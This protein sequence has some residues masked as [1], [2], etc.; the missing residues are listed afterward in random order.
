MAVFCDRLVTLIADDEDAGCC[1]DDVVSDGFEF[2]DFEYSG[3][4]GEEP[5]EEAEISAGDAL[6][7]GDGLG[8]GV[9]GVSEAFPEAVEDEE[10]FVSSERSVVVGEAEA[11]VEL[12]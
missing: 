12:G 6:D 11:A 9:E 5:F 4:L 10:E 1:F 3:Y 8:V 7:G 2:V